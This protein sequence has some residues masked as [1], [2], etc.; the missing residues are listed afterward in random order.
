VTKHAQDA[1]KFIC[2]F[3]PGWRDKIKAEAAKQRRSMNSEIIAAVE[4]AMRIKGVSLDVP[5]K[6]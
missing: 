3:P 4:V 6:E 5:G 2:R 1:D